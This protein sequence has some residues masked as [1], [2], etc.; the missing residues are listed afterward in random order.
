MTTSTPG[1]GLGASVRR[2]ARTSMSKASARRATALPMPPRPTRPRVWPARVSMRW[3]FQRSGGSSIQNPGRPFTKASITASTYSEIGTA[4]APRAHVTTGT[5]S[6]TS[7]G[8]PSMPVPGS[9]TH[10]RPRSST[11]SSFSSSQPPKRISVL[12]S[13]GG[14]GPGR[15]HHL[16]VGELLAH[17]RRGHAEEV[18]HPDASHAPE[19]TRARPA[20]AC[21][22][23]PDGNAAPGPRHRGRRRRGRARRRRVR[24]LVGLHPQGP[25]PGRRRQGAA[26]LQA[27]ARR[28]A[29]PAGR[30]D[31][32]GV[33]LRHHRHRVGLGARWADQHL[34]RDHD[35][36]D[37]R[38]ARA[39]WTRSGTSPPVGT[40]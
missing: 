1:T 11:G 6:K 26:G 32:R 40:T 2:S 22:P 12:P 8:M 7:R 17:P 13:S 18:E 28:A 39:G 24:L 33:P 21:Q 14:S 27:R 23:G 4:L 37:H 30:P 15:V 16:D 31:A 36:H 20:T 19:R 9:C 29:S 10:A 34:P 3:K 25:E 5:R 35:A 38:H